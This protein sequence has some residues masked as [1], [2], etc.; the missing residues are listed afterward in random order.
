MLR[1]NWPNVPVWNKTRSAGTF[2][3]ATP[4]GKNQTAAI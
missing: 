2:I 3:D 4:N 1:K